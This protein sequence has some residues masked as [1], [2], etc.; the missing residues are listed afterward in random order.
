ME[1]RR[2]GEGWVCEAQL[3]SGGFGIVHVWRSATTGERVALKKC[4]FGSEISLTPRHKA[5]WGKEVDIMLRLS[6]PGVVSCQPTPEGLD[7]GSKELPTLCMEFC[8]AGD[9]RR[10]LN[11][12]ASARGLAQ[13]QVL[14]ILND[15]TSALGYLHNRRIIHRDLKPENVVL[16][17]EESRT[18]YK[19]IDLGYAKELGVSS[20]AQS[21]VGTLQYVAPELFLGQDYTKSVDYWSLGLLTHEVVT[22]QRPFLPNMSPGQW[23]EH[24]EGKRYEH[25][26]VV[27]ELGGQVEFHSRLATECQVS[28]WLARRL[29]AWLRSLLD[30]RPETRGRDAEDNVT[31]FTQLS[32]L[33]EERR[34]TVCC[35]V[36]GRSHHLAVTETTSGG[37]LARA[38]AQQ[39]GLEPE[40]QLV[41]PASGQPLQ[42]GQSVAPLVQTAAPHL[43]LLSLQQPGPSLQDLLKQSLVIPGLVTAFLRD[44][45]AS[46]SDYHQR[47]MFIHGHHLMA[48]Q[49]R[50]LHWQQAGLASLAKLLATQLAGLRTCCQGL[51]PRRHRLLACHHLFSESLAHDLVRY[52]EQA[53]RRERVTSTRMLSHWT[54][55]G[56]ELARLVEE[57]GTLHM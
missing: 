28:P 27:Q 8:E 50:V 47:K 3:G 45:R 18:V 37:D 35:L 16:K 17:G 51:E 21:F 48:E 39:T 46:V 56:A 4:K 26:S 22:G 36:T 43:Y 33:L 6:H 40:S 15:V 53:G 14:A 12:P 19:L 1:G 32:G 38:V 24:V 49:Q 29:E 13:D 52:E 30:W 34:L 54:S 31:V 44:P 42:T 10:L 2:G 41:F 25:I 55:T 5:A 11:R 9:L 57:V 23:I 20:L 7:P